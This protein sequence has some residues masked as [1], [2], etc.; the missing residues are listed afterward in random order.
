MGREIRKVPIDWEHPRYT[1]DDAPHSSRVGHYKA[2]YDNDY[3]TASQ[4]WIANL[5]LWEKGQHEDQQGAGKARPRFYWDWSG[6]PPNEDHYRSRHWTPEE[7]TALQVYETVSEGTP[8]TPVFASKK[9]LIDYLVTNGTYWDHGE[10][11]P[12]QA[13]EQFVKNEYAPS[14]MVTNGKIYTAETGFPE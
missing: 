5:L 9:D 2:L 12:R 10:G 7:A 4:E 6:E 1:E 3:E 14:M 13:A 11:W 8:V